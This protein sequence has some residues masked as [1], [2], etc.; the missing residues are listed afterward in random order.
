MI[1]CHVHLKGLNA[2]TSCNE[3]LIEELLVRMKNNNID[4]SVL[5]PYETHVENYYLDMIKKKYDN[6]FFV[7][8]M[9]DFNITD[10]EF[11][12]CI[13]NILS[14]YPFDGIKIHPRYQG[15]DLRSNKVKKVVEIAAQYGIPIM[16]DCLPGNG[17]IAIWKTH[18]YWIDELAK[19][20]PNAKLIIAHLG[21]SNILD[22]YAIV[23]GN[24]NVFLDIS[25]S[26]IKYEGSSVIRDI[27]FVLNE[28]RGSDKLL[29]GTDY[30][31]FSIEQTINGYQSIF[32]KLE[33]TKKEREDVVHNNIEKLLSVRNIVKES[34]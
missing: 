6:K 18:P 25:A 15:V 7:F 30:P 4:K 5:I 24:K 20:F 26:L 9:L 17:K 27:E 3:K 10:E 16:F 32:D 34:K 1:D 2:N 11:E 31:T 23:K 21:G 29:F 28:F 8:G 14:D 13:V 33:F 12:E 22:A 19:Q